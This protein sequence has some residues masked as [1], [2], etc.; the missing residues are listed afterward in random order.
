MK[1]CNKPGDFDPALNDMGILPADAVR[2]ILPYFGRDLHLDPSG[3]AFEPGK[4]VLSAPPSSEKWRNYEVLEENILVVDDVFSP[5][6]LENFRRFTERSTVHHVLKGN[7][8][9]CG[10]WFDGYAPPLMAQAY[11]EL[12][13][14]FPSFLCGHRL[15]NAW[16]YVYDEYDSAD[17]GRA[18]DG[19]GMHADMAAVNINCWL[20]PGSSLSDEEHGGMLIWPKKPPIEWDSSFYNTGNAYSFSVEQDGYFGVTSVSNP[21]SSAFH[22]YAKNVKPLRVAYKQ[23]RCVIFDSALLHATNKVRFKKGF[24]NRRINLTFLAGI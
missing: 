16:T 4:H 23:N 12:Q 14:A 24:R 5:E 21:N 15:K 18:S 2:D 6:A 20:V 13:E 3:R 10:Y 1:E 9:L 8:Y 19:I 7:G 17:P 11:S 22:E